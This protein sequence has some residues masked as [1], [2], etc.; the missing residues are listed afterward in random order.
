M[1]EENKAKFRRMVDEVFAQG[2][3][4]VIDELID[5]NWVGHNPIPG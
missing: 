3:V 1:S 5:P 2:K 4:D